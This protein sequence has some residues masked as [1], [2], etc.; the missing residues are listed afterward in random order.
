VSSLNPVT[1]K[2]YWEEAFKSNMNLSVATP[3]RSGPLLFVTAFYSGPMMLKL[4]EQEPRAALLWNG[5][6]ASEIDTDGLHSLIS[7]PAIVGD[8]IYGICSYG[9][10]RCLNARTG[11]RIWETLA[12][13][14]EKARWAT[15]HMV[16][17]GERFFINNDRGELIIAKLAPD[18]YHEISR[19]QLIKP[20]SNSGNRRELG[21]VNWSHPAY[22]N[23]H[24]VARNDEEIIR[25]SLAAQ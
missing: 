2:V 25:V 4:D 21:A 13:T 12:V 24:V 3:V 18:G 22:A 9:Q 20:T 16:R 19:T 1:G 10:M 8:Y 11:E 17:H 7:T 15:G 14:R 6:S 5:K 23:G